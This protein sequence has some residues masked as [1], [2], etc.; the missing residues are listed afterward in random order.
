M[1]NQYYTFKLLPWLAMVC[2]LLV[3]LGFWWRNDSS[4][5]LC[6]WLVQFGLTGRTTFNAIYLAQNIGVATGATM[7]GFV[8]E[9]S[10]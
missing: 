1:F 6:K 2:D 4:R 3:L 7:G 9:L 8:A 5:N 10:F